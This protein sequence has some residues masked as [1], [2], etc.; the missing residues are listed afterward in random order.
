[1][2]ASTGAGPAIDGM[3]LFNAIT[4]YCGVM[5][6][7]FTCCRVMMPDPAFYSQCIRDSFEELKNAVL[8][9]EQREALREMK[10]QNK[11][12]EQTDVNKKP[13]KVKARSKPKAKV[14][15]KAKVKRKAKSKAKS[16]T[17][18]T[19]TVKSLKKSK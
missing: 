8:D 9:S 17:P 18:T 13:V 14:K 4:T 10:T 6:I 15:A 12:S 7:S 3:G 19:A 2:L 16:K 11:N 1:M 5:T